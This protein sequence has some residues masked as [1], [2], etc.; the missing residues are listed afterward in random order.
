MTVQNIFPANDFNVVTES[1]AKEIEVG[2]VIGYDANGQLCVYGGGLFLNNKQPCNKD[3]LFMV[4]QF[5]AGLMA[6]E[7]DA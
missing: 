6:G 4:E 5:K 3:F 1:A 7:Y 2:I